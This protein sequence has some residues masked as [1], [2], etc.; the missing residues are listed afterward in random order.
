MGRRARFA[1][2]RARAMLRLVDEPALWSELV[3]AIPPASPSLDEHVDALAAIYD[4]ARTGP[5]PTPQFGAVD[6]QRRLAFLMKQ[7][8]TA[9]SQ[10]IPPGGPQ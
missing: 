7:R 10:L 5:K 8:D 4:E 3:A 9:M 1:D 6:A 2:D